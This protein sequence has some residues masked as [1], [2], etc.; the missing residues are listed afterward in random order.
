MNTFLAFTL[1]LSIMVVIVLP[2]LQSLAATALVSPFNGARG[3]ERWKEFL[4][5]YL[6]ILRWYIVFFGVIWAAVALVFGIIFL[7]Q[8]IFNL[9]V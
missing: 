2:P 3:R 5:I 1:T 6:S 7:F 4:G 9:L 8:T